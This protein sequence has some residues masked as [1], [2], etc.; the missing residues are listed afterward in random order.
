MLGSRPAGREA[1]AAFQPTLR[2]VAA[3]E[4][5]EVDFEGI[6]VLTPSWADEFLIPLEKQYKNRVT[7]MNTENA[8]VQATLK[9]LRR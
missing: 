4:Q 9:I 6:N 3:N 7:F 5:I 8:S 1:W 2:Q